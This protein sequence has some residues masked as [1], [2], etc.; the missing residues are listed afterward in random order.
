MFN[1][2]EYDTETLGDEYRRDVAAGRDIGVP[3]NYFARDD[4]RAAAANSWRTQA[5]LLF[6]N[7]INIVYQSTPF[8]ISEIGRDRAPGIGKDRLA[9]GTAA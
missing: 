5:H 3:G 6:A 7:W 2:L 1:H 4:A 9:P 8:D